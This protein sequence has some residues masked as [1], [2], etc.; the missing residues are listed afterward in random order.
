M[1]PGDGVA[2]PPRSI[3]KL[4][5]LVVLAAVV[6]A[7]VWL[8][9]EVLRVRA[10]LSD[11]RTQASE[12]TEQLST[13]GPGGESA[14][15]KQLAEDVEH[16][17]D[18]I[19]G[20]AWAVGRRLPFV[21]ADFDVV[22]DAVDAVTEI[23]TE[24]VPAL[25]DLAAER[26]DGS[27]GVTKGKIDL[28][29]LTRLTPIVEKSD[30]I[31]SRGRSK[32]EAIDL[33][34][35]H[36]PVTDAL[37]SVGQKLDQAQSLLNTGAKA[38]QLA[39]GMLG[40]NGERTYLL[41]FQNNAELRST[42]GIPGAYAVLHVAKGHLTIG[43]QGS[44]ADTGFFNPP[45]IT[46][47][48]DEQALYGSLPG[49]YWQDT[50]FTPDF[51]RTAEILRSMY[52]IRFGQDVDGVISVDPI[53]LAHVLVATG[54]VRVT[55]EVALEAGTVVPILLNAVY[56]RYPEDDPAQNAFF[57]QAARKIFEAFIAG[58]S[59]PSAL[60]RELN[61]A[62]D[63]NRIMVNSAYREEQVVI[64]KTP[65]SGALPVKESDRPQ[66]G[67]YLNDATAA[68]LEYFLRRKTIVTGI[69]CTADGTQ[70]YLT[71]TTLTSAAPKDVVSQGK[72]VTGFAA[73]AAKGEM[74]MVLTFYAPYGGNV[75]RI[76]V[77]GL[78]QTVNK[79]EHDGLTV[80]TVPIK[81]L[82]GQR[83]TISTTIVSGP[84]QR[85]DARFRTTPGVEPTPNNV[86]IKSSCH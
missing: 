22:A 83:H 36:G 86:R 60:L 80:A 43:R 16:A 85:G 10:A 68:K 24:G 27:L 51:P 56:S 70:T 34:R 7:A 45:A 31:F 84:G 63:E 35:A 41:I 32:F 71:N 79:G 39:P 58:G 28:S 23:T 2:G 12:L 49:N 4:A 77:D 66:I 55:K 40:E 42:G 62:V 1:T 61:A 57:T 59:D 44:G 11:A 29:V 52:K 37:E 14:I 78:D 6:L 17:G 53:A 8:T 54:P 5:L 76:A 18:I 3:L 74:T 13:P 72:S 47:T 73:G 81:L 38:L 26:D 50:N 21:G 30:A 48:K 15:A 69:S 19:D 33:D 9:V 25:T 20:P 67:L 64:D 46:P 75:T 65:L 82:P